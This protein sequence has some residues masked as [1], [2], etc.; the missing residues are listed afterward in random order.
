M[1]ENIFKRTVKTNIVI[2]P[3]DGKGR[4]GYITYNNAGF[5]TENI[6]QIVPKEEYKREPFH[7]FRSLTRLP[8][9]WNYHSDGTGRDGYIL[10]N[11]GGL[12]RKHTPLAKQNL[13]RFLRKYEEP[14]VSNYRY[15]LS[16]AEKLHLREINKIQKNLINR[17][18][19]KYKN[20]KSIDENGIFNN[21]N[22][23][24][25]NNNL[26]INNGFY[27]SRALVKENS[28]SN[29]FRRNRL[30]PI[31]KK[32]GKLIKN[33]SNNLINDIK[34][35]K[36]RTIKCLGESRSCS[37]PAII[38]RRKKNLNFNI[39]PKNTLDQNFDENKRYLNENNNNL[40]NNYN[41]NNS[42]MLIN[43]SCDVINKGFF[44]PQT[45]NFRCNNL[46][47]YNYQGRNKPV[48]F[49]PNTLTR[50]VDANC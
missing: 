31:S 36:F 6:K 11:C 40:I 8:P 44:S 30:E 21:N 4:D 28:A 22:L 1:V 20:N 48:S 49:S 18:Y 47:S 29:L 33:D 3:T 14:K 17:L 26:N 10:Y 5:W 24:N 32:Y 12:I 35:P 15:I 9:S 43:N 16:K 38:D 7:V 37:L 39:N 34:T 25:S 27:S 13:Q 42:R 41:N 2:Y 46:K 50:S 45:K 23:I 19:E